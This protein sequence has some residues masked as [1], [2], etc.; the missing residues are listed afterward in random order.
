MGFNKN[1]KED[2]MEFKRYQHVERYGNTEVKD[3]KIGECLVF[4]KMD[5]TNS[6]VYKKG[7]LK[8]RNNT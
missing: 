3:I 2:F 4:P 8:C 6:Q 7:V 1:I 5:G